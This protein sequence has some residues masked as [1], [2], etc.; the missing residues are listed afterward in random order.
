MKKLQIGLLM[1]GPSVERE[2]SL[3]TGSAMLANLDR[4][5]YRIE[6]IVVSKK[7]EWFL[8]GKRVEPEKALRGLD[9]ALLALHG[10]FGEDG[11]M[12][13]FLEHH[14]IPYTGSGVIAS[15]LCMNKFASRAIFQSH[16]LYT[17]RTFRLTRREYQKAE[18]MPSKNISRSLG[19][20]PWV[21]K[22]CSQGSSVGVS[23]AK[24]GA[25]FQKAVRNAF[26]F[27]DTILIEERLNGTEITIPILEVRPEKPEPLPIIEIRP[28]AAEFFNYQEKYSES[29]AEE[30]VPAKIPSSSWIKAEKA[31]LAVHRLL[32]LRGYSRVDCILQRDA[33]Y[34]LEV[35]TLPGMASVSLLPKSAAAAGIDFPKLLDILIANALS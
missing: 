13:A 30:I 18:K 23:I 1:G 17:P 32:G 33:P 8:D 31:A 21:V 26:G 20:M 2:I 7:N 15:A 3:K 9:V 22:P 12:Q 27:D 24:D 10:E 34:I 16:G 35:N 5:K 19:K 25:S 14:R 29:G 28:R 11:R 6:P 4:A